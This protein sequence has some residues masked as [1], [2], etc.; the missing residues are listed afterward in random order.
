MTAA[1]I[2]EMSIEPIV[3]N[4]LSGTG[5]RRSKV[6]IRTT[7]DVGGSATINLQTY[8]PTIADVEGVEFVT[9]DGAALDVASDITWSTYTVTVVPASSAMEFA[10]VVTHT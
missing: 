3:S 4:V 10:I 7:T 5:K 8:D 1:T 9:D 6:F 2:T